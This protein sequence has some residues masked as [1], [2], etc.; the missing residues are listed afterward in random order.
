MGFLWQVFLFLTGGSIYWGLEILWRG[1]S[2]ISMFL[3]GGSCFLLLGRLDKKAARHHWL[4]RALLGA[5]MITGVEL[6]IG[7]VIN[8][9]Y[10]I[11][12]Y[13]DTPGNF[14]GQIC[15]PY[16]LLWMILALGAMGLYRLLNRWFK[17]TVPMIRFR[18]HKDK[19]PFS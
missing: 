10:Q 8:R 14:H 1:W 6:L 17:N 18:E 2:H 15:L 5:V 4:L 11:W 16:F 13:R 12:D 7:M 3:A 9:D 19:R